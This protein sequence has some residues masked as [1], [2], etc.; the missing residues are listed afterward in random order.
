MAGLTLHETK[1]GSSLLFFPSVAGGEMKGREGKCGSRRWQNIMLQ[2]VTL[3][4]ISP[5]LPSLS[6]YI[7]DTDSENTNIC[8]EWVSCG[9]QSKSKWFRIKGE[10]SWRQHEEVRCTVYRKQAEGFWTHRAMDTRLKSS[11]TASLR[12]TVA[13]AA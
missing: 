5:L 13:L 3:P 10:Y 11:L 7:F 4:I 1:E 9:N 2:Y 12:D 8:C 6:T